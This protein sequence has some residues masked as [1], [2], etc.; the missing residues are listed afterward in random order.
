MNEKGTDEAAAADIG[1][2]IAVVV[3]VQQLSYN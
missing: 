2:L 1:L 3:D